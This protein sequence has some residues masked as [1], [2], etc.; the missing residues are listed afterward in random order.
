MAEH[1]YD[2]PFDEA[3]PGT[4]RR[5]VT[6]CLGGD[7]DPMLRDAMLV[8]ASELVTHAVLCASPPLQLRCVTQGRAIYVYVDHG[9]PHVPLSGTA[10]RV[11]DELAAFLPIREAPGRLGFQASV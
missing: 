2:L 10:R 11:A 4:G 8:L 1:L 3:A 5:A 9:G 6:D 7:V